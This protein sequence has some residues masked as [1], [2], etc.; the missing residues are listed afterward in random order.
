MKN[1]KAVVK[2]FLP[3]GYQLPDKSKQFMKLAVGDN[4]IRMLTHPLLGFVFFNEDNKPVRRPADMGDFTPHEL[5]D[6]KAKKDDSGNFEGSRHFWMMLVWSR[7][8][9]APKVLEITQISILKPL[10]GI[11]NDPDWGDPRDFD[12][13]ISR[14]G[15]GKNDTEFTVTPKPHKPVDDHVQGV[16]KKLEE[17]NMLDL[18]AIWKN[19]YPFLTYEW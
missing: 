10:Y 17:H 15:T 16:L 3:K 8:D 19:E 9:K 11:I 12:I 7:K 18:E 2:S 4:V 5:T 6:L 14:I 1:N 13:N